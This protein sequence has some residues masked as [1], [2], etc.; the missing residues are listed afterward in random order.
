MERSGRRASMHWEWKSP[1]RV[2][3]NSRPSLPS[4]LTTAQTTEDVQIRRTTS[5][6]DDGR[7][8]AIS[9]D[10]SILT[11]SHSRSDNR[12]VSQTAAATVWNNSD[13]SASDKHAYVTHSKMILAWSEDYYVESESREKEFSQK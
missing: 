10:I 13:P 6:K 9:Y 5:W 4:W 11:S 3:I 1:C 7:F 12:T 2:L 8:R